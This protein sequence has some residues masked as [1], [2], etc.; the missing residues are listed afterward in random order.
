M[1][2]KCNAAGHWLS[3]LCPSLLYLCIFTSKNIWAVSMIFC[4]SVCTENKSLFDKRISALY[5]LA[6]TVSGIFTGHSWLRRGFGARD[7]HLMWWTTV[8][9]KQV[10]REVMSVT[11]SLTPAYRVHSSL[12]PGWDRLAPVLHSPLCAPLLSFCVGAWLEQASKKI[13]KRKIYCWRPR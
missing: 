7:S 3:F 4:A 11:S 9:E 8:W 10:M 13:F 12:L 6:Q 5:A 1:H 2:S